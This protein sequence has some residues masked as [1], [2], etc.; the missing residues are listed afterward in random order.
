MKPI[1]NASTVCTISARP[2]KHAPMPSRAFMR[3][4]RT[5]NET[6]AQN[7]ILKCSS[8]VLI[9][10]AIWNSETER[11]KYRSAAGLDKIKDQRRIKVFLR[12]DRLSLLLF[13]ALWHSQHLFFSSDEKCHISKAAR[14]KRPNLPLLPIWG[15]KRLRVTVMS[16]YQIQGERKRERKKCRDALAVSSKAAEVY[17]CEKEGG[18]WRWQ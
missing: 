6:I 2:W 18:F 12:T 3:V 5:W 14:I 15:K 8:K 16:L 17:R 10:I 1:G 7:E 13:L 11:T 9:P 4:Y